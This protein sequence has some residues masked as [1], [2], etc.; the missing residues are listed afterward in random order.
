[1]TEYANPDGRSR[2]S[3]RRPLL[4]VV[5]G[6]PAVGKTAVCR[7]LLGER[8]MTWLRVDSIEQAL[9][10]SG[11]MA[12]D[13]PGGAGYYAAAAVAGDVLS[14]GGDVLVECVNPLPITRRLWERTA[15]DAGSC[16]LQVELVC[17]DRDEHRRRVEQRVSDIAGLVLPDWRDVLQRDYAPWP[18]ADLRLDTGRL[19]AAGVAE[20]IARA[21]SSSVSSV[22]TARLVRGSS[23]DVRGPLGEGARGSARPARDSAPDGAELVDLDDV[24]G[25]L[26]AAAEAGRIRGV[27]PGPVRL[28]RLGAGESYA[29]WLLCSGNKE[30]VVRIPRRPLDQ[31]PRSMAAEFAALEQVPPDLG[32]SAVAIALET[33]SGGI[34][35]PDGSGGPDGADDSSGIGDDDCPGGPGSTGS[36]GGSGGPG[37]PGGP[38]SPDGSGSPGGPGVSDSPGS[39]DNPLGIPYMVTTYV[40]GRVLA[41]GDWRPEF[42]A[43]LA[44]QIARL[45]LAL[46]TASG[47]SAL[48]GAPTQLPTASQEGE[49]LLSWWREHHPRTLLDPRVV[50]LLDPW[51][52]ALG[53]FDHAFEGALTHPLIHGDAVLTNIV[54]DAAGVPRLIDFE[55]AGPGDPAKDLALIGGAI[56]G[57]PWYAPMERTEVTAFVS[58]YARCVQR[59]SE[60]SAQTGAV[61]QARSYSGD[62]MVWR[63]DAH[64]IDPQALLARRDAWELLDRLP[65]LLYCLSR[66]EESPWHA[67]WADDLSTGLSA[68]LT[69]DG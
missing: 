15:A 28:R 24:A 39:T 65:N 62:P 53:R 68:A 26:R 55:W 45:H 11:E 38:G 6:L 40:P 23:A 43:P 18:E 33:G 49:T 59:L 17:S 21:C 48:P 34:G 10:R 37:G 5:G 66:A 51:R 41:P 31:L 35:G 27:P 25:R 19:E 3:G 46:S 2:V 69:A 58:E 9:R 57:G 7:A 56:T 14:T 13:M 60:E 32:A 50:P 36:T 22:S 63:P 8:P 47:E 4:V 29:A 12:P 20:L 30:R 52:R 1:M 44:A 64:D 54:F 42:A 61:P 16:L 67:R